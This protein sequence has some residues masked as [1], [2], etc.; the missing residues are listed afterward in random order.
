[1]NV[2]VRCVCVRRALIYTHLFSY[3]G[4]LISHTEKQ[5]INGAT[6]CTPNIF[7]FS[8]RAFALLCVLVCINVYSLYMPVCIVLNG[9]MGSAGARVYTLI[10]KYSCL[11]KY[12]VY[13]SIAFLSCSSR[14]S[15]VACCFIPKCYH[16]VSRRLIF[17][18]LFH[19]FFGIAFSF[20]FFI[21]LFVSSCFNCHC[22]T[23]VLRQLFGTF[24]FF[25]VRFLCPEQNFFI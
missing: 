13:M 19:V 11:N 18:F 6:S 14:F 21:L 20:S 3:F 4:I 7:R 24:I 9:F 17:F 8:S 10:H 5:K 22:V 12:F 23:L 25:F 15:S 2:D 16:V 1:M